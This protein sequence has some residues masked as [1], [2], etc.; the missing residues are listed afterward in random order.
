VEFLKKEP[1]NLKPGVLLKWKELGPIKL[2][3][4]LTKSTN[5]N[6][7]VFDRPLGASDKSFSFNLFGQLAKTK[8]GS[9]L[10]NGIG[11]AN[12]KNMVYEGQFVDDMWD[13]YGRAIY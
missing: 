10:I 13:G 8:S 5:S 2:F 11:R 1:E 3:D 9:Q 12:Y 7:I 4:I 6:P